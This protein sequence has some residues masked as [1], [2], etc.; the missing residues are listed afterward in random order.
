MTAHR[1]TRPVVVTG[2]GTINALGAGGTAALA[3]SLDA[4]R[5][6][7][8]PIRAFDTVGLP[9]HLGAEVDPAALER[10][11][12]RDA[13]RRMSRICQLAVA[14]CR[15]AVQDAAVPAGPGLGLVVGTEHGDF[16]SSETFAA[17]YLKR[18]PGGLSP[19]VFPSTVMN[20][21]GAAAAIE[22]GAKG[23]T[24][25]VNQPT[26]A[27]DLALARGVALVAAGRADAVVAG[28]VDEL[29][30]SVHRQLALMG[31][32]SPAL[33]PGE[34]GCRPYEGNGPVPGEGATFV[35]L[36]AADQARARGA[37]VLAEVLAARWASVIGAA[38]TARAG[39]GDRGSLVRQAL[40]PVGA[41]ALGACYGAA[42]GDPALDAWELTLLAADLGAPGDPGVAA[43]LPPR[44][45]AP[46]F[47]QHGGLGA[48]R[49]SAAALDVARTG[50][51][52]LVH[53]V[54]RG[55]C[56][57]ALVLGPPR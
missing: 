19:M 40:G 18:G 52:V 20:A 12:D 43:L 57:T 11:L 56:R 6:G 42:N 35:V 10:L 37:R 13:A 14:A 49:A 25:T 26:V 32:L 44:S 9:S 21:M 5:S 31:A 22:V 23:P 34:E 41:A 30:G 53:G 38:H 33:G 28:G 29:Y 17:G 24:V 8:A 15:L 50:R 47:G 36:E 16:R 27:G 3:A 2:I 55:G 48:L 46:L 1:A 7:V 39:R 4:R 54:A 51:P 45:L